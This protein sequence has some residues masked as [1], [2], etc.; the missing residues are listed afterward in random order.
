MGTL[1]EVHITLRW[2]PQKFTRSKTKSKK[3]YKAKSPS[4]IVFVRN[5]TE[6]L[7]LLAYSYGRNNLSEGDEILISI[8]EHHSNLVP[9]QE[10]AKKTGAK[11]KYLYVDND[12]QIPFEEIE[13]KVTKKTKIFSCT[14]ASNVVRNRSW[15]NK[16]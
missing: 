3:I 10:V 15:C 11:L 8:I 12:G 14:R 16:K 5:A 9:W 7:N 6:A 4:E 1:T 2:S 13:K